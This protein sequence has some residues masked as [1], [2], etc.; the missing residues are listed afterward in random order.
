MD[1]LLTTADH[2]RFAIGMKTASRKKEDRFVSFLL[3]RSPRSSLLPLV[4]VIL[5]TGLI[6]LPVL[7]VSVGC[8]SPLKQDN[9][10]Y[11][12]DESEENYQ[13]PT[14]SVYVRVI[15]DLLSKGLSVVS[16]VIRDY[17]VLA[18]SANGLGNLLGYSASACAGDTAQ[19]RCPTGETVLIL[20]ANLPADID[21]GTV[22][23]YESLELVKVEF[24]NDDPDWPASSGKFHLDLKSDTLIQIVPVPLMSK[25]IVREVSNYLTGYKRLEDP[26]VR[27]TGRS[28]SAELLRTDGF[29]LQETVPDATG[30]KLPCDIGIYPQYPGTVLH[31][32][33]NDSPDI[34]GSPPTRIELECVID[35]SK[36]VF[37]SSLPSLGRGKIV[38]CS[39]SVDSSSCGTWTFE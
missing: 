7:L 2:Y 22:D 10:P 28:A 39:L 20:L 26:R 27:L 16:P 19:L 6:T 4:I 1:T 9:L 24:D 14:D 30:I 35:G 11:L 15:P 29:R 17:R 37:S 36:A 31:C 25:V 13:E 32:Y 18:Y 5:I 38:S 21:V 3:G 34:I 8:T 33:P 23:R 12:T